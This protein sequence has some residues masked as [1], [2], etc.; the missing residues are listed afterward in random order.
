MKAIKIDI[1]RKTAYFVTVRNYK[2]IPALI[3][4]DCQKFSVQK[5]LDNGD[6]IVGDARSD[7][8]RDINGIICSSW[9]KPIR[10]N[11]ILLRI[12]DEGYESPLTTIEWI[13]KKIFFLDK[14]QA[15]G[16]K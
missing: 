2:D 1:E 9:R 13:N 6:C 7:D 10:N 4:N 3:G 12:L 16:Y 14:E 11:V 5:T 8:L 15:N